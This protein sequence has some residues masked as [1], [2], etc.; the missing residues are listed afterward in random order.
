MNIKYSLFQEYTRPIGKKFLPPSKIPL[1]VL[2]NWYSVMQVLNC[3]AKINEPA[4][5]D[6]TTLRVNDSLPIS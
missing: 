5:K 2:C 6:V 1:G 4:Q 3:H